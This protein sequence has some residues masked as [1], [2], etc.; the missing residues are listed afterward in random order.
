MC[1]A[2]Y[3]HQVNSR[4]VRAALSLGLVMVLAACRKN[5]GTN[6][7]RELEIH[8]ESSAALV[9]ESKEVMRSDLG[10]ASVFLSRWDTSVL[11]NRGAAG[12]AEREQL[13]DEAVEE[14]KGG[15][16]LGSF[17]EGLHERREVATVER[18][19]A[20]KKE[21]LFSG[22]AAADA[23]E[24]LHVVKGQ[25]L[26]ERLCFEAGYYYVGPGLTEYLAALYPPVCQERFLT[27]YCCR[28]AESNPERAVAEYKE[29][30][31][32]E[33][34]FYGLLDLVEYLVPNSDFSKA[35]ALFPDDYDEANNLGAEIRRRLLKRWATFHPGAAAEYVIKTPKRVKPGTIAVVV[36][37][38]AE[39][40]PDAAAEWL[41]GIAAGEA[42]DS[43]HGAL[44][45]YWNRMGSH[46][47]AMD[48][49]VVVEDL[50]LRVAVA[51]EVFKEWEKTD[52]ES[53]VK[54]WVEA[55][56]GSGERAEQPGEEKRVPS[57]Q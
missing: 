40:A 31:P 19:L 44:A 56:P 32:P 12:V 17:I 24:W 5:S 51:T 23:R 36:E 10:L 22:D 39:S 2:L 50:E 54:A 25:K 26:K 42:R 8:K 45:R 47:K 18:L 52:R 9:R 35:D 57:D 3:G 48:I 4:L 14:L 1:A 28:L 33:A 6:A 53:A 16:A 11:E 55:F 49:A 46:A 13:A 7:E 20:E 41:D 38:W 37:K 27:G 43:G 30:R 29:L 15:A 21:L 34:S